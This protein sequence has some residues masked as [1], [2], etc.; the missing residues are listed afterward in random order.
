MDIQ[1]C[2]VWWIQR[3]NQNFLAKPWQFFPC[4]QRNMWSC[5]ILME[6]YVI[7]LTNSKCFLLSAAISWS[8]WRG[9][10]WNPS[11]GFPKGAHNRGHPSKPTI[12][13]TSPSLNEDWPLVVGDGSFCLPHDLFSIPY[14]YAVLTFHCPS[15]F[16]LKIECFWCVLSR[17][18]CVE[19][20]SRI[21]SLMWNPN[22]KMMNITK[23]MDFQCLIWMFW[24]CQLPPTWY[25]V[26]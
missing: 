20:Q 13:K 6:D 8:N 4:H 24:V 18:L 14:Y 11:F 25:N 22:I 12:Y 23:R 15:Q 3:I 5:I 7:L 10:Y 19:I 1:R 21:F 16:V 26:D 2:D 17:E 9:T